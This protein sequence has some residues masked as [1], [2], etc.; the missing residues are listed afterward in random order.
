MINTPY[1]DG[2]R[3]LPRQSE[4]CFQ[5][6][7]LPP[8]HHSW[9]AH[10]CYA[11]LKNCWYITEHNGAYPCNDI[12]ACWDFESDLKEKIIA[13]CNYLNIGV[14]LKYSRFCFPFSFR[15]SFC[16][17]GTGQDWLGF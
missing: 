16:L 14:F 9:V 2:I 6:T 10:E 8:S 1:L 17:H 15:I 5:T 4:V 7:A 3:N 13:C 12:S 11:I